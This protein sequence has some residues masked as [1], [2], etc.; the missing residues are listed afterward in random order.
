MAGVK[1]VVDEPYVED[2][3]DVE[4]TLVAKTGTATNI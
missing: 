2:H 4:C 3:V 1:L